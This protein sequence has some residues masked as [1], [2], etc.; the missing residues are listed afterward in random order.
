[1][2]WFEPK[3]YKLIVYDKEIQEAM[4]HDK[5][6]RHQGLHYFIDLWSRGEDKLI[7]SF[8]E[9]KKISP[10]AWDVVV[11]YLELSRGHTLFRGV[12]KRTYRDFL[13]YGNTKTDENTSHDEKI[14]LRKIG[15][16]PS[17]V[18]FASDEPTKA[19]EFTERGNPKILVL[20]NE[21]KLEQIPSYDYLYKL[22][23]GD[24]FKEAV[25]AY[26]IIW[27]K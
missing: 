22:K 14:N 24:N 26:F 11:A 15:L 9:E 8:I 10:N 1:M 21:K 19:W 3:K 27:F 7:Y 18:L 25:K 23:K 2:L 6:H 16:S 12:N 13:R 5:I 20:Y 4:Y 17:D